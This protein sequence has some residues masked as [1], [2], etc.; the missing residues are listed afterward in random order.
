MKRIIIPFTLFASFTLSFSSFAAVYKCTE[1]GVTKFSQT[2]CG[3][4][5]QEVQVSASKDA[6]LG[7]GAEGDLV[8][9][10]LAKVRGKRLWK[11]PDTLKVVHHWRAWREDSSGRRHMLYLSVK[12]KNDFGMEK[13]RIEHCF[14][15]HAGTHLSSIQRFVND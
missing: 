15:N 6:T 9:Q 14:L 7:S 1:G 2:P 5:Y 12:A 4:D 10:C 11:H 13:T 8:N 3:E